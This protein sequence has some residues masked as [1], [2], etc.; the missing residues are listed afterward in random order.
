MN[1]YSTNRCS[2][3]TVGITG[4]YTCMWKAGNGTMYNIKATEYKNI[5][6]KG[7][8]VV[9]VQLQITDEKKHKKWPYCYYNMSELSLVDFKK[10]YI[11]Q[12]TK[13][14]G[15]VFLA[16]DSGNTRNN[17]KRRTVKRRPSTKP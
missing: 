11:E 9:R 2:E 7:Q 4:R 15:G 17:K 3:Y 10:K 12:N 16:I 8:P 13:F 6:D 14:L 1:P 5:T